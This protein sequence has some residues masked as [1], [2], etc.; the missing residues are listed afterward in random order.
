M[1]KEHVPSNIVV[2]PKISDYLPEAIQK[3]V[4]DVGLKHP[5]TIYPIAVGAS[6][7]FV[8]WLFGLP[9]LYLAALAGILFGPGWAISQIF[10]FHE[11]IGNKYIRQLNARQKAY[12]HSVR[13]LLEKRL[14]EC[15]TVRGAEDH[16]AQ[17]VM[18]FKSIQEKLANIRELL[19]LKLRSEELTFGRFLGAAEQVS[20]GVLDNLKDIVSILK[21]AGSIDTDHIHDRLERLGRHGQQTNDDISQAESLKERL[22][23]HE[24]QLRK[25]NNL[26]TK[27]EEAMTEMGNISAAVA[28]WQTDGRFAD[29]DFE[30]AI[31]RLQEL[32]EQAHEYN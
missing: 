31:V 18:Q 2:A 10:F 25:V 21:S 1:A 17:G 11:K 27:N 28:G 22:Q 29:T 5:A 15:H 20:L 16:V 23:L 30:S 9:I 26:L 8:G 12:E 32:A 24:A 14:E 3:T 13:E 4:I 7:G 6:C 19:E